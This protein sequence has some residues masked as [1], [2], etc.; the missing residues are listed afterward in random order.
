MFYAKNVYALLTV[1]TKIQNVNIQLKN[2]F[3]I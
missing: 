1:R 2:V 3:F